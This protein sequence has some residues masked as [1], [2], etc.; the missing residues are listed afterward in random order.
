MASPCWYANDP[1]VGQIAYRHARH[2]RNQLIRPGQGG[3]ARLPYAVSRDSSHRVARLSREPALRRSGRLHPLSRPGAHG[4]RPRDHGVLRPALPRARRPLAALQGAQ[5]RPLHAREPVPGAAT[6]GVQDPH[7][8]AGVR[9]HVRRRLPRAVRVLAASPPPAEGP[10]RRLRH[11]PRQPVPRH[12]PARDD[13]GRLAH[14]RDAPP[15]DHRRPRPRPRPR[16]ERVPPLHAAALVRL[17]RHADEGGARDAARRHRVGVEQARHLGPD[18]RV[19]RPAPRRARRRRPR[20]LQ[21]DA[22]DRACRAG[23]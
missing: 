11:R 6:E 22:R 7:R 17:P 1:H 21:A 23:S 10:P 18:G 3:S 12:R 9:D 15:P 19:A 20:D 2:H 13:E 4:S 14:P 16:Q 5:P 8:R